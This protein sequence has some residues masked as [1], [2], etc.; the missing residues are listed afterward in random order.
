MAFFERAGASRLRAFWP[1]APGEI[2]GSDYA[3][4]D[5]DKILKP[6]GSGPQSRRR[7]PL[8]APVKVVRVVTSRGIVTV[9]RESRWGAV[10]PDGNVKQIDT[11]LS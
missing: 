2:R 10:I 4:S 3:Q 9:Y 5:L 11:P 7:R 8:P 6:L 1:E